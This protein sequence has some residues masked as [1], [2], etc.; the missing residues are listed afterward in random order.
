MSAGSDLT[1]LLPKFLNI[2]RSGYICALVG[3]LIQ[4]WVLVSSS[5]TFTSYLSAYS[6]FLSSIAGVIFSDYYLVRKG[7]LDVNQLYSGSTKGHYWYSA[8]INWRAYVAYIL[9]I[10]VNIVGFVGAVGVT[11]PDA[12][13]KAYQLNFFL[14][15]IVSGGV[16]WALCRLS[17]I[18]GCGEV[19]CAEVDWDV[20]QGEIS[21]YVEGKEKGDLDYA[22]K[23]GASP[24]V[25]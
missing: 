9:G 21:E 5:S 24:V 15:L 8:G 2:R 3:I 18:P 14:G 1:A 12:A 6:T 20:V 7:Y 23:K 19:W 10:V 25:T 4:P 16:Y 11:V 22:L 13:Q 17:P